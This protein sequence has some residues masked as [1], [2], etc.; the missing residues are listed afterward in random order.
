MAFG[1]FP[2]EHQEMST[3]RG[4]KAIGTRN[5]TLFEPPFTWMSPLKLSALTTHGKDQ[6][7][8]I[9]GGKFLEKLWCCVGGE[10]YQIVLVSVINWVDNV[11]WPPYWRDSEADVS[12]V[13]PSSESLYGGQFTSSTQLITDTKLSW[14]WLRHLPEIMKLS[15]SLIAIDKQFSLLRAEEILS[16][17]GLTSSR[18]RVIEYQTFKKPTFNPLGS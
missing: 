10:Y 5:G 12:S 13:R 11:N 9:K 7:R 17:L 6:L 4:W 1:S 3:G 16:I 18:I 8:F 14:D 15:H 2:I